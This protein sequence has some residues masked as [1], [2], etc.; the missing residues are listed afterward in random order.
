MCESGSPSGRRD[1]PCLDPPQ[2]LTRLSEL[3]AHSK[4]LEEVD[5]L[6]EGSAGTRDVAASGPKSC[7]QMLD[8]SRVYSV[9]I[10]NSIHMT[11]FERFVSSIETTLLYIDFCQL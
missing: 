3:A 9:L 2:L 1:L 6:I 4:T 8:L 7:S 10:L 11:C 5:G